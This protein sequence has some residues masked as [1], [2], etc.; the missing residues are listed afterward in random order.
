MTYGKYAKHA[1]HGM[2]W[3][4]KNVRQSLQ[5]ENAIISVKKRVA[6]YIANEEK[7]REEEEIRARE[8]EDRL[9]L[10]QKIDID[11]TLDLINSSFAQA[12]HLEVKRYY[13]VQG[14]EQA[15]YGL[16]FEISGYYA[17]YEQME[18]HGLVPLVCFNSSDWCVLAYDNY[19]DRRIDAKQGER[20]FVAVYSSDYY[21]S[22][23]AR[24][25]NTINI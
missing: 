22:C 16:S 19:E 9:R 24:G 4:P 2:I 20:L 5:Q 13:S 7:I 18:K 23:L 12:S 10:E 8:K 25:Q 21:S 14:N 15:Y 1:P 3:K 6:R 11:N 17:L